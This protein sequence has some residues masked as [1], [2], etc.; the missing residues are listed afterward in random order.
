[1]S[2]L[3]PGSS[4]SSCLQIQDTNFPSSQP[5]EPSALTLL[6]KKHSRHP[7]K[8][9]LPVPSSQCPPTTAASWCLL[10]P[11]SPS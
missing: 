10:H 3:T 11:H 6:P 9:T 2:N 8:G 7:Q 5:E 1:M 4:T